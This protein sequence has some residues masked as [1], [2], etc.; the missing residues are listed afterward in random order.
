MPRLFRSSL[1]AV[2]LLATLVARAA[3]VPRRPR[4]RAITAFIVLDPEHYREQ[5]A[6]A[7]TMLRAARSA[8]QQ[9]GYEVQT[10]RITTR[11]FPEYTRGMSHDD[12]LKFLHAWDDLAVQEGFDTNIGP[13]MRRDSDDP[14]FA[15]LAAEVLSTS[16]TLE[17]SI[18]LAG[19]DGLH[20]RSVAAA[21]KAIKYLAD[22]SPRSQGNFNFSATAMLAPFAPFYP[23][24][25]HDGPGHQF[26]VGLESA[27]VVGDV[28]AKNGIADPH[29]AIQVLAAALTEH[30]R[31]IEKVAQDVAAR[32]GWTYLGLDPTPAPGKDASIGDAIERFTGA[33][34]G[35]SGTLTAASV[36]TAAVK[37]VPV[38][39]IGY[40]GLMLP[41]LE[42][43]L[44]ARRWDENAYNLDDLLAFSAVCG[45]GL[46]TVPLPGDISE[47]QLARILGDVAALALKWHKPLSARLQP[48]AG[49]KPGERTAFDDPFLVNATIHPLP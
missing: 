39:Q 48:V 43:P 19:D 49:A 46:D 25:W 8:F 11:P 34:F 30:A 6:D 15:Q 42:D 28:F 31:A 20:P 4:V 40:S 13:A 7:L 2:L 1:F 33:R 10:I 38:K 9:A 35:S 18:F 16:K 27:N 36:I 23:G 29:S 47:E 32:T 26:T 17:A 41:V 22:H 37:A 5:A 45:T 24:S 14:A 44:L 21:A 3:D 12:A